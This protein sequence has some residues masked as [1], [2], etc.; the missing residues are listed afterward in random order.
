MALHQVVFTNADGTQLD[1]NDRVN[2]FVLRGLRGVLLPPA[3]Q[4]EENVPLEPGGRVR[5]VQTES[6]DPGIPIFIQGNDQDDYLDRLASIADVL[7]PERGEGELKITRPDGTVRIAKCKLMGGLRDRPVG[8]PSG[9]EGGEF[10]LTFRAADPYWYAGSESS[11]VFSA[12]SVGDF[13]PFFPMSLGSES[14]FSSETVSNPG[15]A[16]TWPIWEITGPGENLLLRNL[17]SEKRF[18]MNYTLASGRVLTIDARPGKKSMILDT[19][20]QLYFDV[21]DDKTMWPL[22]RGDNQIRVEFTNVDG[23]SSVN[24]RYTARYASS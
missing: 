13:F 15:S 20:V 9:N 11:V 7:N 3:R 10:V 6:R 12:A 16:E 8:G 17:T 5:H 4:I 14:V 2:T 22:L 24:M 21:L 19:G 23:N 1:L 18:S